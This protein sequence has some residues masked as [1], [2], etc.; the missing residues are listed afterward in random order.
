MILENS[1]TIYKALIKINQI[2]KKL[3]PDSIYILSNGLLLSYRKQTMSEVEANPISIASIDKSLYK[4]IDG[5]GDNIGIKIDGDKLYNF[6]KEYEFKNI[7]ISNDGVLFNF[8][9]FAVNNTKYED[10]FKEILLEKGFSKDEIEYHS[11]L[12]FKNNMDMYDLYNKYRTKNEPKKE[13]T[14]IS[15][16][17]KYAY[18]DNPIYKKCNK[19]IDHIYDADLLYCKNIESEILEIIT[20]SK[21]PVTKTFGLNNG[22][23]IKLR[24]MKSL[25]NP[26]STKS[27]AEI[28]ILKNK[29]TYYLIVHVLNSGIDVFNIYKVLVY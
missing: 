28:T 14:T 6:S 11:R 24:L 27:N 19:L 4:K 9:Y 3:S 21:Q 18:I 23:K 26:I 25:F 13:E 20:A 5:L 7:D 29:D 2:G 22:N 15:L 12:G 8:I 16:L 10:T 17:C 1:D